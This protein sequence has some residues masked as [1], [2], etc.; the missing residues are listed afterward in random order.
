MEQY[1]PRSGSAVAVFVVWM[2]EKSDITTLYSSVK[3]SMVY[4]ID[5]AQSISAKSS[6]RTHI[7]L[8]EIVYSHQAPIDI[9]LTSTKRIQSFYQQYSIFN[10]QYTHTE[11][12]LCAKS[13]PGLYSFKILQT[14]ACFLF[15][16]G[17]PL[18]RNE[19]N[20]EM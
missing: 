7:Y 2:H 10:I 5:N 9:L 14:Y 3:R 16:C 13:E 17:I 19:I 8:E 11:K 20:L 6:L 4:T 15:L 1:Y 12:R 18:N